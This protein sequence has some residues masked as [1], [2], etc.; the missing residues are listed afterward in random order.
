MPIKAIVG[1]LCQQKDPNSQELQLIES[2]TKT[3]SPT[4]QRWPTIDRE[5][6][7]IVHACRKYYRY[8][9]TKPFVIYTDHKPLLAITKTRGIRSK[10][11]ESWAIEL[12][13]FRFRIFHV[14]GIDNQMSDALSRVEHSHEN[15]S[16]GEEVHQLTNQITGEVE[17]CY[18]DEDSNSKE[19][20]QESE[21]EVIP[22][23]VPESQNSQHFNNQELRYNLIGSQ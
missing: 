12:N 11:L 13:E 7:A 1:V 17:C 23:E 8:L 20:E 6:F 14:K 5:L 4:Q 9:I 15:Q 2:F 10:R 22:E 16:Q 19:N 21:A 3:L 18:I